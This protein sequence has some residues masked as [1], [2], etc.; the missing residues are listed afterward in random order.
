GE[1][2]MGVMGN[3]FKFSFLAGENEEASPFEPY[4]VTHGHDEDDSTISLAGPNGWI[5]WFPHENNAEH[6]LRGMIDNTPPSM[7]AR[8]GGGFN[9]TILH[10]FNPYNAEEIEK[11]GMSKQEVKEY[12]VEN[13]YQ[14]QDGYSRR[15]EDEGKVPPRQ[16]PQYADTDA[17]KIACIGGPGRVNAIAGT[18][19]GGPVTKKIEFP[20]NFDDLVE[21]YSMERNWVPTE[22]F[23]D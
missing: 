21:E 18:S 6:V 4:H 9:A 14:T 3:P 15:Y 17:V 8:S 19:I 20:N 2:D 13:S 10:A 1:K 5:Q 23:Y 12:L 7:R 22:G 16:E 11:A